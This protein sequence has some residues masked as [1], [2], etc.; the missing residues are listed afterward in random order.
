MSHLDGLLCWLLLYLAVASEQDVRVGEESVIGAHVA[1]LQWL[2]E[3]KKVVLLQTHT[4]HLYRSTNGGETWVDI[5]NQMNKSS[6]SLRPGLS[7]HAPI[8][9]LIHSPADSNVL[10]ALGAG[11][12]SFVSDNAGQTW[13][14]I[15]LQTRVQ[16]FAF[17]SRRPTWFLM[18]FWSASCMSLRSKDP[19]SHNLFLTKD[20]GNTF[21]L[22]CS[23]IV[24]FSWGKSQFSQSDRVYLT[25]FR[26]KSTNQQRLTR[27][28]Q[29]IDF[30]FTDDFGKTVTRR[31][32]NGNKFQISYDYILV[33][34]V[35]D[36][37][38]QNVSLMVSADGGSSFDAAELPHSIWQHSFALLD[39]SEGA[40][41][42]HVN[43]GL[44]IGDIYISDHSGKRFTMSL[45]RNVR[46]GGLCAFEKVM[47]I[48]GIYISNIYEQYQEKRTSSKKE[49]QEDFEASS[50][51]TQLDAMHSYRSRRLA[52]DGEEGLLLEDGVDG[53]EDRK[54]VV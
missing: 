53:A 29:G 24:Q 6:Q 8:R 20:L 26:D 16:G 51:D 23:H 14:R 4:G 7:A 54:S 9:R 32:S 33:V 17:H 39:A 43:Q 34:K 47:N 15:G 13:T 49:E 11:E 52:P 1:D 45:S 46:N 22:V 40:L 38:R 37:V 12:D 41:V 28:M 2:G 35:K 27:W 50:T 48:E 3:D 44:N 31:V 25:H 36:T 19:C 21:S 30:A 42:L 18:S 10:F 5:R